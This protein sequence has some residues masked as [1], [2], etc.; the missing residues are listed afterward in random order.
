MVTAKDILDF[1]RAEYGTE[2]SENENEVNILYLEG[3]NAA[4]LTP[5][6][7]LSDLWNDTSLIIS[8]NTTVW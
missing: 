8:K 1:C 7:D 3:C 2:F 6:P 4:D 5:N